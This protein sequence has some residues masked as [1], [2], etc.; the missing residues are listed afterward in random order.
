MQFKCNYI[1]L[2]IFSAFDYD[3]LYTKLSGQDFFIILFLFDMILTFFKKL[4]T[5]DA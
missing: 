5:D 2:T 3:K 4:T 1:L